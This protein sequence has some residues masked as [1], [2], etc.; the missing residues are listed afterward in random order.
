MKFASGEAWNFVQFAYFDVKQ[1]AEP[2]EAALLGS[3]GG[4]GGTGGG[5][6]WSS[7]PLLGTSGLAAGAGDAWPHRAIATEPPRLLQW[8]GGTIRRAE[9]LPWRSCKAISR[10][11]P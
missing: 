4:A 7:G 10:S 6:K 3:G 5:E 8:C 1:Q 11:T 9:A 2:F